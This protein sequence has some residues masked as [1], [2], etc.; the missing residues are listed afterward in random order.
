MRASSRLGS[1]LRSPRA[2]LGALGAAVAGGSVAALVAGGPSQG[3]IEEAI[4]GLGAAAPL[5]FVA[6]YAVLTVLLFPGAIIT[7]AGGSFF[8][9][10]LGTVLAV[11]GATLGAAAAFF[12]G[13][14][15]GRGQVEQ[16]AGRRIGALDRWLRRRGLLAVLYV[17]LI[18]V[19]PFNALN[20]AAGVTAVRTRDYL[21]GTA[22]GIIPGAFA[23]AALGSSLSDPLSPEFVAAVAMIVVLAVGAPLV[24]RARRS[25]ARTLVGMGP[26]R[27]LDIA[28]VVGVIDALLLGVLVYV[29][30][31]D[32][33]DS[34]ISVVGP[35][36]GLGFLA[37]LGLTAHGARSAHWGWWYPAA[38]LVTGGPLGTIVGDVI[39]RRRLRAA[40]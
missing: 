29:A 37:L 7:A 24:D 35:I 11:V 20:Y 39:L 17:R 25:P 19:V 15:L 14:R 33:S 26:R 9:A 8:G 21:L 23:F 38:V 34:A 27:L 3:G 30:F 28:L 1:P 31:V 4:D 40:G 22:I 2:R 12:I 13:R 18:P 32:R 36:H 10:V 5:T 16:I 6:V